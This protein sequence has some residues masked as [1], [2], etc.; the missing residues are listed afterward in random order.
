MTYILIILVFLIAIF[1]SYLKDFIRDGGL[2]S[3]F[4]TPILVMGFLFII[5]MFT[6]YFLFS[7]NIK[8]FYGLRF[9][10]THESEVPL[11]QVNRH[12][13]ESENSEDLIYPPLLNNP[14]KDLPF[15]HG[16]NEQR[17]KTL[18]TDYFLNKANDERNNISI[19]TKS[20]KKNRSKSRSDSKNRLQKLKKNSTN[21]F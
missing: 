13:E 3:K 19:Q 12:G 5:I 11:Q 7:D 18:L 16:F 4:G 9:K 2:D 14:V 6:L 8:E 10:N 20:R 21:N 15:Q 1:L 17:E